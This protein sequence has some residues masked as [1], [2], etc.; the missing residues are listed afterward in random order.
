MNNLNN[1]KS[2]VEM[3]KLKIENAK[4]KEDI[5]ILK[6]LQQSQQPLLK[7]ASMQQL[8]REQI[9]LENRYRKTE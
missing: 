1:K 3:E 5:S 4:L 2:R 6:Q 9:D 8:K 7:E